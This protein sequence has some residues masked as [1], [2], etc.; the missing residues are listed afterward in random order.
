MRKNHYKT[1]F[2]PRL[3]RLYDA[4]RLPPY[5]W[6]HLTF[7]K[8]DWC[9]LNLLKIPQ[10][11][12]WVSK[13]TY[14]VH[15]HRAQEN[16]ASTFSGR[17]RAKDKD[18]YFVQVKYPCAP[19]VPHPCWSPSTRTM[20]DLCVALGSMCSSTVLNVVLQCVLI[21]TYIY[22]YIICKHR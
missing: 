20:A 22:I 12:I 7:S 9:K 10:N 5:L 6:S 4:T 2:W 17:A 18:P 11:I 19:P 13:F 14:Y 3:K 21:Y 1:S 8:Q 15:H 16:P